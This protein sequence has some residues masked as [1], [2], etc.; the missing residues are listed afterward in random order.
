M[1]S[2]T[3]VL[4]ECPKCGW[5]HFPVTEAYVRQWEE[6][7]QQHFQEWDKETLSHYG[8]TDETGPPTRED[9]LRCFR[10]GNPDRG[11]FYVSSEDLH[12]HTIQPI[13]L[14]PE[15]EAAGIPGLGPK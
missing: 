13:L 9:Y 2:K 4:L 1:P 5:Y 12:G 6:E 10:C 15:Q 11:S 7:W 8:I 14:T 3:G